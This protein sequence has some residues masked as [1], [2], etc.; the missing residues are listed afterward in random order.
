M[1]LFMKKHFSS[2]MSSLELH[3]LTAGVRLSRTIAYLQSALK[4]SKRYSLTSRMIVIKGDL[5][6][7]E[8]W[9][10]R[11]AELGIPVS[12]NENNA[13]EIIYCESSG[14]SWKSIITEIINNKNRYRYKFYG[15]GTHAAVGSYSS[16]EQGEVF[17][18]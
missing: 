6:E 2:N 17:E 7:K 15:A 4:K 1:E 16:H 10:Q 5:R 13:Q 11:L 12:E 9:K 8:K 18:I 14:K 3:F